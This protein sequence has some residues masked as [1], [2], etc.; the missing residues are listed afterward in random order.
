LN[1]IQHANSV[2]R[3]L[4]ISKI[5]SESKYG[6]KE[7]SIDTNYVTQMIH[8]QS[9]KKLLSKEKKK[10]ER[11]QSLNVMAALDLKSTL[12]QG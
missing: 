5:N 6:D 8:D 1:T 3:Q 10:H 12:K 9:E 4:D 2:Q 11:F 7:L